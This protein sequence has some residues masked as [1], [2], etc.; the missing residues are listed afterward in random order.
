MKQQ[1]YYGTSLL[2]E[3]IIISQNFKIFKEQAHE[4]GKLMDKKLLKIILK[5]IF[6]IT[7][8]LNRAK[9]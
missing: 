7:K 9:E 4:T 5:M 1:L 8:N 2:F 6:I 3:V